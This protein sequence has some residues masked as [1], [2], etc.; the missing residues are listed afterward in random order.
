MKRTKLFIFDVNTLISAFVIGSNSNARA[1][2]KALA[3]GRIITS[4]EI[5]SEL[6]DVF[7]RP[8]FDRFLTLEDRINFLGYLDHQML[9]WPIP[10][11]S[12]EACRD[13]KDNKYLELA[14]ASRATAIV[15][16]DQD[17]LILHPFR[18]IPIQTAADFLNTD[19]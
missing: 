6:S 9:N 2:D 11:P 13:P 19:Y 1:F 8:K 3:L 5:R 10:L 4:S 16:G 7:L 17:L 12:I 15:T 18:S 14:V